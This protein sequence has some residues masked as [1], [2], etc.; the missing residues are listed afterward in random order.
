MSWLF[1][2]ERESVDVEGL[3]IATRIAPPAD[4]SFMESLENAMIYYK[5][6]GG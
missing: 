2:K 5:K 3:Y 6:F 1:R 4:W